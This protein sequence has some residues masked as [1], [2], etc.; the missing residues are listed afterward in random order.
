MLNIYLPKDLINIV[1]DYYYD[2]KS[3]YDTVIQQYKNMLEAFRMHGVTSHSRPTTYRMSY[4][5]GYIKSNK[6][7]YLYLCD[8]C[9]YLNFLVKYDGICQEY[10]RLNSF[11][12]NNY[13]KDVVTK[14]SYYEEIEK[15][16]QKA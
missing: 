14:K 1:Y 6:N 12:R 9:G 3:N 11:H 10:H 4:Y 13:E 16:R 7:C 5:T 15:M 2:Y 8:R